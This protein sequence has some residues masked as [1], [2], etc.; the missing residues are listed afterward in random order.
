MILLKYS[1]F[2]LCPRLPETSRYTLYPELEFSPSFY[3][4]V[5]FC[6]FSCAAGTKV[7]SGQEVT[8]ISSKSWPDGSERVRESSRSLNNEIGSQE[9]A[10]CNNWALLGV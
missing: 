7:S 5:S 2:L 4:F 3:G 8:L 9:A 10:Q 6:T 1:F